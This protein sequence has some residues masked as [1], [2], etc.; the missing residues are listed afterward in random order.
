MTNLLQLIARTIIILETQ[1][2]L[3]KELGVVVNAE[4]QGRLCETFG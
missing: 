4:C 2:L 1:L 3:Q